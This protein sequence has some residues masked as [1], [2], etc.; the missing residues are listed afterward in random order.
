MKVSDI[1]NRLKDT[2]GYITEQFDES[3]VSV[4]EE[5]NDSNMYDYMLDGI[6]NAIQFFE[7]WLRTNEDFT[8]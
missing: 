5:D 7:E 2:R 8:D 6:E 1:L 3:V 4:D